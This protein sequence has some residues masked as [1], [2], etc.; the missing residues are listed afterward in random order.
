MPKHD[1]GW[2]PMRRIFVVGLIF[3]GCGGGASATHSSEPLMSRT[4]AGQNRCN[5]KAHERPFV[6]EWD[7]TDM[8]SFEARAA[9][10]IIFVRYEGCDLQVLDGCVDDSVR[11]SLG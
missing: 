10:D 2:Q 5:A 9:N 3:L 7:A 11:G 8:S 1:L 6:I 4:F